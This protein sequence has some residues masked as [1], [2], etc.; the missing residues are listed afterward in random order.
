[1]PPLETGNVPDTCVVKP[2]FPQVGA[3]VTPPEISALPVATSASFDQVL[4]AD[5]Y[6]KSPVVTVL[7]PV[8]PLVAA[9]VPVMS[10]VLRLM[11]SQLEFVPSV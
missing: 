1:V 10:A 5:P 8:P 4:V 9:S 11:V 3:V 6:N 2:I 7:C